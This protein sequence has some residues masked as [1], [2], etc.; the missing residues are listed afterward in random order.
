M[1]GGHSNSEGKDIM[2][3]LKG[4]LKFPVLRFQVRVFLASDAL[5]SGSADPDLHKAPDRRLEQKFRQA[6]Q[7]VVWVL[8]YI[9]TSYLI[10]AARASVLNIFPD[11]MALPRP[12]PSSLVHADTFKPCLN[13]NLKVS[14]IGMGVRIS[15]PCQGRR[16]ASR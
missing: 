7:G 3:S 15:L 10:K 9:C 13:N 14:C 11:P 4:W 6:A 8:P 2:K 12:S 1:L 5:D 16:R